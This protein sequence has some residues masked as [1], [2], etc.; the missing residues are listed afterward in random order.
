MDLL[1]LLAHYYPFKQS[2]LETSLP[3]DQK[4]LVCL[5]PKKKETSL[6]FDQKKH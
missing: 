3:L 2:L 6:P 1:R 4:K 5:G